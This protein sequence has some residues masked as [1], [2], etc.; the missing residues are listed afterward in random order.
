MQKRIISGVKSVEFVSDSISF[1]IQCGHCCHV[2][3][4]NVHAQTE[5]NIDD[6]KDSFYEELDCVLDK[7]PKYI[8]KI[9]LADSMPM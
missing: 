3:V 1:T 5:E 6:L 2:I 4:L 9:V 8:T 7:V